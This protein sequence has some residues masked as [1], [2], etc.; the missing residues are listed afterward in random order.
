MKLK[1]K[2]QY[3]LATTAVALVL[4]GLLAACGGATAGTENITLKM[5]VV[6]YVA[7]KTDKWLA[8]E[9]LIHLLGH[10]GA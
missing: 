8:D 7:D 3:L 5:M 10:A 1:K 6:D 9:V 4:P 2:V